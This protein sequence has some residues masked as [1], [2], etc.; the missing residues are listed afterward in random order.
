MSIS[1]TDLLRLTYNSLCGNPLRS[2]LTTVG[3]FVGVASVTATLQVSS[4]GKAIIARQLAERE[5]PQLV[6]YFWNQDGRKLRWEDMAFLQQRLQGWQAISTST[7]LSY[8]QVIFEDRE[9]ELSLYAVSPA[10]LVTTGRK[11][12]Q[13][14]FLNEADF[15]NFR[16]VAV[17]DEFLAQEL[18]PRQNP[19]G[20]RIYAAGKPYTVVGVMET[21]LKSEDDIPK[22]EIL[23]PFSLYRALTAS[24]EID[25]IQIRPQSLENLSHLEK[26]AET[27]L[28]QR[29]PGG[30]FWSYNNVRDILQQQQTLVLVSRGLLV[31]GILSLVVGGV[32]I[33]NITLASVS[34]RT[35]EI[36]L[37]LAIGAQKQEILL[38]FVLEA[39]I[40]SLLGGTAALAAVHGV[41]LV[42]AQTFAL[43][44]QF[45]ARTAILALGSSL[46]VGVG[47][48]FLPARQASQLDPVRALRAE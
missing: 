41:T 44:Y 27:L 31:L 21:K 8:G 2:T 25:S 32:G 1:V 6:A 23:V 28:L 3:I 42:V 10:Y 9:A 18:F 16:A 29:Y 26:E 11:I 46:L 43:P 33:A 40:L 30:K 7:F 5:A 19:V 4:I 38:Q 12:L 14:R 20:E 15:A 17:I 36:G 47:S 45:E 34:E 37:R 22:G 24:Q 48:S 39:A 35:P 13:G